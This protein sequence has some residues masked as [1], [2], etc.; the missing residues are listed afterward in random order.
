MTKKSIVKN[1]IIPLAAMGALL[2]LWHIVSLIVD[3]AIL[4]PS[5][6]DTFLQLGN[7]FSNATFWT[8][9]LNTLFRS[10]R[11]FAYAV[12]AAIPLAIIARLVPIADRFFD[13][14][15]S[16]MRSIPT[17]SIIL[18]TVL[19]FDHQSTPVV[20]AFLIT[21]PML[22]TSVLTA[23]KNVDYRLI[24]M[25]NAYKVPFFKKLLKLYVP[26]VTP[27][28]LMAMKNAVSLSLKVTIAAEVIAQ[29]R[30]SIGGFMQGDMGNFDIAGLF[31]WTIVAVFFSYLLEL[32][33]ALARHL[34]VR[35][36]KR[37]N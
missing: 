16:V 37:E 10:L 12:L 28:Y 34:V 6:K 3:I 11:S 15:I 8:A 27:D 4:M 35:R 24:E 32:L 21:F 31:G 13:P 5:P 18:I 36:W 2:L 22:Y 20:I 14:I 23:M 19:W 17:M 29:T 7:L 25:A 33:I 26:S 1:I 30:V 9:V